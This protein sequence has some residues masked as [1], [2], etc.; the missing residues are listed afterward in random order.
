MNKLFSN[1]PCIKG[2]YVTEK[3]DDRSIVI[4]LCDDADEAIQAFSADDKDIISKSI[5]VFINSITRDE[6]GN[7]AEGKLRIICDKVKELYKDIP[8]KD[9]SA[10]NNIY[11]YEGES[12]LKRYHSRNLVSYDNKKNN[13]KKTQLSFT[14]DTVVEKQAYINGGELENYDPSMTVLNY[15]LKAVKEY[16]DEKF[17][18][19]FESGKCEEYTYSEIYRLARCMANSMKKKG[20]KAGDK[21]IIQCNIR[22][23]IIAFWAC[24]LSNIVFVP[25][26]VPTSLDPENAACQV[27]YHVYNTIDKPK[28]IISSEI[29]K[30]FC[31][32]A[33]SLGIS[34][35]NLVSIEEISDNADDDFEPVDRSVD[36]IEFI[37][38][39]SGSTGMPKGAVQRYS[40]AA[41]QVAGCLQM[42]KYR[43]NDTYLNW[44]PLEHPGGILMFHL[45]SVA[46]ASKQIIVNTNYIL[47]KPLRWIE[48]IDKYRVNSTWAPHFAYVLLAELI[49]NSKENYNWDLSCI[50]SMLNGGEMVNAAGVNRFL[51]AFSKF[52]MKNTVVYPA[53]GMCETCSGTMYGMHYGDGDLGVQYINKN[54]SSSKVEFSSAD[55][56]QTLVI[57][58]IGRPIPGIEIRI[59]DNNNNIVSEDVIGRFQI[60]GIPV[61]KGY[62]NNPQV[63]SES[64]TDDG[65]FITGDL[66]FIHNGEMSI[67]GREKDIII[68]NGLNYNNVEI[69][70]VIEKN[71]KVKTSYSGV[72]SVY[73]FDS[74]KDKVI[75]FIVPEPEDT[76]FLKLYQ[77]I[78]N[79]VYNE[80]M[81]PID[82]IIPLKAEEVPK[83]NLGKIQRAKLKKQYE[84][85][86]YD[87][88]LNDLDLKLKNSHTIP[89][90]MYSWK[91]VKTYAEKT[92]APVKTAVIYGN[93]NEKNYINSDISVFFGS[94][95]S[96]DE[97][98]CRIVIA[99]DD[100]EQYIRMTAIFKE[101]GIERIICLD[102]FI[103]N[104]NDFDIIK[105]D[106]LFP[107]IKLMKALI[108]EASSVSE[109]ILAT[110]SI[111]SINDT[112]P[113]NSKCGVFAG[114]V[115]CF[116]S[117]CGNIHA[118]LVDSDETS[119]PMINEL[120]FDSYD[121]FYLRDNNVYNNVLA[122]ESCYALAQK[123]TVLKDGGVY[124]VTG[125]LGGIGFALA[126]YIINKVNGKLLIIGRTEEDELVGDKFKNLN[127]L[128][129]QSQNVIYI[130]CNCSDEKGLFNALEYAEQEFGAPIDGIFHM[131]GVGNLNEHWLRGDENLISSIDS[132][133]IEEM[134]ASKIYGTI[135]LVKY[136]NEHKNTFLAA[137]SSTTSY[138]GASTFSAYS[139][140]NS[141]IESFVSAENR[142]NNR[143]FAL[144]FSSWK[145]TGMSKGN[146][147]GNIGL[148]RGFMDILPDQG[149]ISIDLACRSDKPLL[150]I[151]LDKNGT[152][153]RPYI[154][155][156]NM[157]NFKMKVYLKQSTDSKV[158]ISNISDIALSENGLPLTENTLNGPALKVLHKSVSAEEL[159]RL[160]GVWKKILNIDSITAESDFFEEG[161]NS[162]LAVQ[163]LKEI[164]EE[165]CIDYEMKTLLKNS[166]VEKMICSINEKLKSKMVDKK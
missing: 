41:A 32:M 149:V 21:V 163:L 14:G 88:F 154:D 132:Y 135:N 70:A 60:K 7:I 57:T 123:Q 22:D 107:L 91:Y 95:F 142:R 39:T 50:E 10:I 97:D 133:I 33:Y 117:E 82:V 112:E 109:L 34:S 48:L 124:C 115:S 103:D 126:K 38:F 77:E 12:E 160:T 111:Y 161:G 11:V 150:Y 65:W 128:R 79:D 47:E 58:E 137:A 106:H 86:D 68:I 96:Y 42:Y 27:I 158:M 84:N 8:I 85:G 104:E 102:T 66:G 9:S 52:G 83:T 118:I 140:A 63:N 130:D 129:E 55:D 101:L 6:K 15:F 108:S 2:C 90:W 92:V 100:M 3:I 51:R 35:E 164:R 131:A 113:L 162:I 134:Y 105:N 49:E 46:L 43:K 93:C 120:K 74:Q 119:L 36:D 94:D 73:D 76:D 28:I 62:Y 29:Y 61:T 13:S 125:G 139:S 144:S 80:I 75:A 56:P 147:F 19:Y 37:F 54:Q 26:T 141:F 23:I 87:E 20:I 30:D 157:D 40:A 152:S 31:D 81:L 45:R 136:A 59:T 148:K 69:E 159:S 138:W 67:T 1:N 146:S 4:V 151:G 98:N 122:V 143:I 145:D 71:P 116:N 17:Y 78:I 18:F 64:F 99:L 24:T 153:I 121:R 44:M 89:E 165:Y 5:L 166:S 72:C 110:N 156:V 127:S 155:F 114:Y 25:M 53:W 16:P